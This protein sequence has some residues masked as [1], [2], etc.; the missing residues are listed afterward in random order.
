MQRH[1]L[2]AAS[3]ARTSADAWRTISEL[4]ADTLDRSPNVTRA[5]VDETM[6]GAARIGRMLVAGGHL[7]GA[8]VVLVAGELWLEIE[9]VSGDG[10]LTLEENLNPVP[11]GASASSWMVHLPTPQPLAH[12]VAQVADDDPHL[13]ADEPSA[14]SAIAEEAAL[15]GSVLDDDALR[16]W[17][18]EG[19]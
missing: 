9:T 8:P 13:S 6:S 3:P 5:E 7:E 12:L 18:E 11:G 16:R 14:S 19:Q 15:A 17:V 1:R 10:A 4:V 2:I